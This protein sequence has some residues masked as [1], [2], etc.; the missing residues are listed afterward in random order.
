L[1]LGEHHGLWSWN[2]ASN[3]REDAKGGTDVA[4][5]SSA[6]AAQAQHEPQ[7]GDGQQARGLLRKMKSI[8]AETTDV[9]DR[10]RRSKE[11]SVFAAFLHKAFLEAQGRLL[12]DNDEVRFRGYQGE[13]RVLKILT[14]K[15]NPPTAGSDR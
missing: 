2:Q 11:G 1:I 12:E 6:F 14:E 4:Q 9:I 15:W 13:A 10:L 8:D 7:Q 3:V 5:G